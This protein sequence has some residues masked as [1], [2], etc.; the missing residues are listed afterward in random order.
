[1]IKHCRS[2]VYFPNSSGIMYARDLWQHIL[3]SA[4]GLWCNPSRTA[5][6]TSCILF[7]YVILWIL[8]TCVI[9]IIPPVIIIIARITHV[10]PRLI[11]NSEAII[12]CAI[13]FI[14]V[15]IYKHRILS[16]SRSRAGLTVHPIL[17]DWGTIT[18]VLVRT[19]L[20][21]IYQ[22]L[23]ATWAGDRSTTSL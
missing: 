10:M 4:F 17:C 11:W 2:T 18:G 7:A 13:N 16:L 19:I 22:I 3:H 14:F 12:H 1:M 6:W 20:T 5:G 21:T 9:I 8:E 15:S 23:A